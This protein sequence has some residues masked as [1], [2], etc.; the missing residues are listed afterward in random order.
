MSAKRVADRSCLWRTSC[1]LGQLLATDHVLLLV[2]N[3][4]Q[5]L[6]VQRLLQFAQIDLYE[7]KEPGRVSACLSE[8]AA[9]PVPFQT[10]KA[11]EKVGS[12]ERIASVT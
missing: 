12:L 9:F 10:L 7:E 1:L 5:A 3:D 4:L 2:F 8:P 11:A 6:S